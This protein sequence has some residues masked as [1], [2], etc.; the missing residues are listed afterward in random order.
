M[1]TNSKTLPTF[2]TDR[3]ILRE[4]TLNDAPAYQKNFADYEVIRFLARQVPWPFPENGV[5][6]F[7]RN[8]VL[9][10]L[11][12]TRWLWGIFLK[13][14]PHELIGA[15]DLFFPGKPENRGFWLARRFWGHGFMTEAVTPVMDFAFNTLQQDKLI[16]SNARGND[17]S[18]RVKEKTGARL[19]E[20]KP[21]AFVDPDFT[22]S[23]YWE[24][25]RA[26][27]NARHPS[28]T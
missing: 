21:F 25:T 28:I 11:G 5:E 16:F 24:L 8:V 10:E 13:E 17:R 19:I 22:E 3:L 20:T 15:V 27:W 7:L 1:S 6:E 12:K 2:E 23:E 4:V 14:N 18:R 9:P 26:E